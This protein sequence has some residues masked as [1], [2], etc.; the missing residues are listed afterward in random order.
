MSKKNKDLS[1][2]YVYSL[3]F[4]KENQDYCVSLKKYK[5]LEDGEDF[6]FDDNNL[7]SI[8]L[9]KRNIY[10]GDRVIKNKKFIDELDY[11]ESL[12]NLL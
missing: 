1:E 10:G 3:S 7:R 4:D 11:Y 5:E 12:S 6:I 8:V 9:Y 2:F